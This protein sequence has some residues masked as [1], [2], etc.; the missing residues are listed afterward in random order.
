MPDIIHASFK[1]A[2]ERLVQA[3]FVV[4]EKVARGGA[5]PTPKL[6]HCIRD[7][8]P[9]PYDVVKKGAT[10]TLQVYNELPKA[11]ARK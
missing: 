11:A 3:G 8:R 9:R 5:A 10:I 7:T 6:L 4:N 1:D 2:K